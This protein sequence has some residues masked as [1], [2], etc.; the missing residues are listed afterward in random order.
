M[1][2]LY[3]AIATAITLGGASFSTQI[4]AAIRA[5]YLQN[6]YGAPIIWKATGMYAGQHTLRNNSSEPIASTEFLRGEGK[7][8]EYFI[9]TARAVGQ[10]TSLK[11]YIE[12]IMNSNSDNG[13]AI[14]KINPGSYLNPRW[15]ITIGYTG[16]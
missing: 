12:E 11:P 3:L 1:N 8:A 6:N 14:I 16:A 7:D 5:I 15:N 13:I 4:N 2:R 9:A 10:Y